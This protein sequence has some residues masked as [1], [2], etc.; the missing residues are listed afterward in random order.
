M[1]GPIEDVEYCGVSSARRVTS[2]G[3]PSAGAAASA[4]PARQSAGD[5]HISPLSFI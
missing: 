1:Q 3:G 4:A 5:A 2:G